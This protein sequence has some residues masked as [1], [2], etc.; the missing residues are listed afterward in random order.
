M[1]RPK[2]AYGKTRATNSTDRTTNHL[3]VKTQLVIVP[4]SHPTRT[5]FGI[6]EHR[7]RVPCIRNMPTYL[8][9]KARVLA[10][11]ANVASVDTYVSENEP[12]ADHRPH[13]DRRQSGNPEDAAGVQCT[14]SLKIIILRND[15]P[16]PILRFSSVDDQIIFDVGMTKYVPLSGKF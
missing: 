3:S 11:T 6:I 8:K 14:A 16:Q 4:Y 13:E 15:E 2:S 9:A 1:L 10:T 7:N 5:T 12:H